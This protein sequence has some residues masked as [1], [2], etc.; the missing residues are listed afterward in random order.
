M[1]AYERHLAFKESSPY[2]LLDKAQVIERLVPDGH[3]SN[4]GRV[5]KQVDQGSQDVDQTTTLDGAPS[6]VA[7]T[8]NVVKIISTNLPVP[9]EQQPKEPVS[10]TT[11]EVVYDLPNPATFTS[12]EDM[13]RFMLKHN[14]NPTVYNKDSFAPMGPDDLVLVVQVHKREKYLRLL[15]DSLRHA[16]G[17]EKVLLVVS[18]DFYDQGVNEA[19]KSVDFCKVR[20]ERCKDMLLLLA[21]INCWLRLRIWDCYLICYC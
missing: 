4:N 17:V 20:V 16:R 2:V 5:P 3:V 11:P 10:T 19:V 15:L 8:V 13:Q 7:G 12:P 21:G 14:S 6:T 18:H 1:L 9:D